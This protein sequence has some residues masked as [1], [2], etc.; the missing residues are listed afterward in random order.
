VLERPGDLRCITLLACTSRSGQSDRVAHR[1][2]LS[3]LDVVEAFGAACNAH[4]LEA[5][6]ELCA[7]DILFE[8]TTPPD[9]DRVVGH[10]EL[11]EVWT[12]LFANHA[13]HVE[14]EATILAGDRVVQQCLYSWGDGHVRAVDLYRVRDGRITEKLSYVKG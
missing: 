12:P 1:E 14:V 7:D 3:V 11:R 9:G 8:S 13:T 4:D 5:A 2:E 6:L 10:A